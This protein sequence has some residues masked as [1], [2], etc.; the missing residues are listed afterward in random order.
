MTGDA[1]LLAYF[2]YRGH[3][4]ALA[5][6][7]EEI[8]ARATNGTR[9]IDNVRTDKSNGV[10]RRVEE[11]AIF[12]ERYETELANLFRMTVNV[13]KLIHPLKD[14]VTATLLMQRYL[15]GRT[16]DEIAENMGYSLQQIYRRHKQA[17]EILSEVTVED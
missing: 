6:E 17:L 2:D 11:V 7:L 15:L 9:T 12:S 10:T 5:E 13:L 3:V 4:N 14:N 1:Y 8:R 16:Y